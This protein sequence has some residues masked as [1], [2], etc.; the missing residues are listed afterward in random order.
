MNTMKDV[1]EFMKFIQ[2]LNFDKNS[3]CSD[4]TVNTSEKISTNENE[5]MVYKKVK[6]IVFNDKKTSVSYIQ[7]KL[8]LGYNAVNKAIEQLELDDVIS[9]R[10]EN[11]IRKILK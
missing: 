1:I 2:T 3:L 7:R 5:E 9:F 8:G 10:D 6:S 4:K 11:G